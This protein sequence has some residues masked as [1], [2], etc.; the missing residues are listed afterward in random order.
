MAENNDLID[1]MKQWYEARIEQAVEK[2]REDAKKLR[3]NII[4]VLRATDNGKAPSTSAL[5]SKTRVGAEAKAEALSPQNK[6]EE[7]KDPLSSLELYTSSIIIE[8]EGSGADTIQVVK[9]DNIK[10][11][12]ETTG[13]AL[14][15]IAKAI[16]FGTTKSAP[17][18]AWRRA[19]KKL[20]AT[21]VYKK[22]ST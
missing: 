8:E 21:G 13:M 19:L 2:T 14:A 17:R 9:V 6:R 20:G 12:D 1:N 18:P 3:S 11:K 7:T 15:K 16:E 22:K 10:K 4:E 5:S